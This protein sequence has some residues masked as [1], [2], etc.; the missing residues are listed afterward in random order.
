MSNVEQRV[1]SLD[2]LAESACLNSLRNRG[3]RVMSNCCTGLKE[4]GRSGGGGRGEGQ[5][6]RNLERNHLEGNEGKGYLEMLK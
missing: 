3:N 4:L 5:D 1:E 6:V 2:Y